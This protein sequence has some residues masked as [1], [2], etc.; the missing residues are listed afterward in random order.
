MYNVAST[1]FE[2]DPEPVLIL[3][4]DARPRPPVEHPPGRPRARRRAQGRMFPRLRYRWQNRRRLRTYGSEVDAH[5]L[6]SRHA[7]S[8]E[9]AC[10]KTIQ[11]AHALGLSIYVG[12]LHYG[13][14]IPED[15][16]HLEEEF[17]ASPEAALPR[18]R[19]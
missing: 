11:K 19:L 15:L 12:E 9:A 6:L 14:D 3:G 2:I 17:K 8:T 16:A 13:V 5:S 10:R 18:R 4:T 1:F 7:A